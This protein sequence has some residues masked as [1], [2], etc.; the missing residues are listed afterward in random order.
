MDKYPYELDLLYQHVLDKENM[1]NIYVTDK[2]LLSRFEGKNGKGNASLL[3]IDKNGQHRFDL[4]KH[5]TTEDTWGVFLSFVADPDQKPRFLEDIETIILTTD[6]S[7]GP[8]NRLQETR[9][10]RFTFVEGKL[11]YGD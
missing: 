5:F 2:R 10:E 6:V 4:D 7:P 8:G 9:I 1:L 3:I 11:E